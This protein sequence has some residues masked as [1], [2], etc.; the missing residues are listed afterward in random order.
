MPKLIAVAACLLL[1]A[2]PVFGFEPT[3]DPRY[4]LAA[5]PALD[6]AQQ[7]EECRYLAAVEVAAYVDACPG[8]LDRRFD[9]GGS[10]AGMADTQRWL[11]EWTALAPAALRTAVLSPQNRLRK[12]LGDRFSAYLRALPDDEV[13][14]E[15]SRLLFVRDQA[16]VEGLSDFVLLAKNP[17]PPPASKTQETP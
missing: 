6:C 16:P 10:A 17:P 2:T 11:G 14:V 4:V 8:E 13:A 12:H 15:C 9:G 7:P 1:G 5:V 3:H